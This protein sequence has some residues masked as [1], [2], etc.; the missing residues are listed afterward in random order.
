MVSQ[1]A[2]GACSVHA[3]GKVQSGRQKL[4]PLSQAVDCT[5]DGDEFIDASDSEKRMVDWPGIEMED[6]LMPGDLPL[7][8]P[9]TGIRVS[10]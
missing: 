7:K 1:N 4:G 3:D 5:L 6:S 8:Y 9:P 2:N 10:A